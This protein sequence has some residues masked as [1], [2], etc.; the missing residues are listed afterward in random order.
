MSEPEDHLKVSKYS[1]LG[2]IDE[3]ILIPLK[4]IVLLHNECN[5]HKTELVLDKKNPEKD[6][7]LII[8]EE[9]KEVPKDGAT[10]STF[11]V[12]K[13][14]NFKFFA[15]VRKKLTNL[16]TQISLPLCNKFEIQMSP[17]EREQNIKVQ[18]INDLLFLFQEFPNINGES[19]LE[20]F[21]LMKHQATVVKPRPEEAKKID[22][23]IENLENLAKVK[24]SKLTKKNGY[25]DFIE[26]IREE[27]LAKEKHMNELR[28]EIKQLTEAND[29]LDQQKKKIT[30]A[31]CDFN[32]NY[33][34]FN[35]PTWFF[36]SRDAFTCSSFFLSLEFCDFE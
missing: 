12:F 18:T 14:L 20:I 24:G 36:S 9:L 8:L 26:D 28:H 5:T 22:Q 19:L 11:F 17:V 33:F 21:L 29:E 6:P 31:V 27:L 7:L 32:F 34:N 3:S 4:E 35:S 16:E 2:D 25:N 15:R 1:K 30:E 10:D 23:V 13:I